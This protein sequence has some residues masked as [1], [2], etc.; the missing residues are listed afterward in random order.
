MDAVCCR[1]LQEVL[2][3]TV[4]HNETPKSIPLDPGN[5]EKFRG[6]IVDGMRACDR[7]AAASSTIGLFEVGKNRTR[8]DSLRLGSGQART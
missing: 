8:K 1:V 2:V 4:E 5:K 3:Y 6:Q 7:R